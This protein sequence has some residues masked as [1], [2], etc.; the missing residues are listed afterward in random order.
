MKIVITLH[1][2]KRRVIGCGVDLRPDADDTPRVSKY[3]LAIQE[4]IMRAANPKKK[5]GEE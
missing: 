4:A 2:I 5:E 3:G 1:E